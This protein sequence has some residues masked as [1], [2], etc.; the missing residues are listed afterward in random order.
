MGQMQ[1]AGFSLAIHAGHNT[2]SILI[3]CFWSFRQTPQLIQNLQ[4]RDFVAEGKIYR[5]NKP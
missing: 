1:H 3:S 5:T 2:A 4:Q